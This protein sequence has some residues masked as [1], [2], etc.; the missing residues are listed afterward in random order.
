[1]RTNEQIW[2]FLALSTPVVMWTFPPP[3]NPV[4][5]LHMIKD[6]TLKPAHVY[7]QYCR[8]PTDSEQLFSLCLDG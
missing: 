4:R 5:Q 7:V 1:M 8:V 6:H 3:A 2:I